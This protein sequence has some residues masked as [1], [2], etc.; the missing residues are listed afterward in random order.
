M[1]ASEPTILATCGGMVAGGWQEAAYGPL[2][3]HAIELSGVTGRAPRVAH[4]NTAGGDPRSI[5]GVVLAGDSAG[6]LCWHSGG[7]TT[8]FGPEAVVVSDGLRLLPGSFSP[9]HDSQPTRRPAFREAIVSG[10][11]PPGYGVEEGAGLVYRGT[12]MTEVIAERPDAAAWVVDA[13]GIENRL[14]ARALT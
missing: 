9:H 12:T 1:T 3:R 8:S 6:G 13:A 5:E 11:I 4:V 2:L 10:A 7:T 14:A